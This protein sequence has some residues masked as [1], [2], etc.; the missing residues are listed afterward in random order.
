MEAAVAH[1]THDGETPYGTL[2]LTAPMA[3]GACVVTDAVA[4][5]LIKYPHMNVEMIYDD[6]TID[7]IDSNLDLAV[8]VGWLRDSSDV[9][10]RI[11]CF[12]QMLV[13]SPEFASRMGEIDRPENLQSIN[14]ISN[15]ALRDPLR[16]TLSLDDDVV[17][18]NCSATAKANSTAGTYACALAGIGL[19]VLPDFI[20]ANDLQ[21]GQLKQVLPSWSIGSGDINVIYPPSRFRPAK[22]EAFV[23][24]LIEHISVERLCGQVL[25]VAGGRHGTDP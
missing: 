2:V 22:V 24:V 16:W 20:V 14:W 6:K 23:K 10:R 3:Y 8:R 15:G 9:A 18:I 7:R 11:G 17:T 12:E 19:A 1:L 25:N 21:T 5:F 13:C 4:K